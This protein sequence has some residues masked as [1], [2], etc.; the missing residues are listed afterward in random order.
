MTL[1]AQPFLLQLSH[2]FSQKKTEKAIA[3][4][5]IFMNELHLEEKQSEKSLA[6]I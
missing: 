6:L 1:P 3:K 2:H 4:I 5:D